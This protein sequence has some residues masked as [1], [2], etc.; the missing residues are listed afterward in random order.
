[1]A[2]IFETNEDLLNLFMSKYDE[3][4]LLALGINLK[5]LSTT[6][7][8][9]MIKVSR[10]SA[11]TAFLTHQDLQVVVFEEAFE[12][13]PIDMQE[14]LIETSLSNVWFDSEK[15]KLNVETNPFVQIFNMRKKYPNIVDDIE[16]AYLTIKQME[17]EEK[18]QKAAAR[19]AKRAEKQANR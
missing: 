12:R 9:E 14:R 4:G 19:E 6:K 11:T 5:V 13:L 8:K 17:D 15:D 1:M 3:T 7:Q 2:K 10:T 16:A 18:E